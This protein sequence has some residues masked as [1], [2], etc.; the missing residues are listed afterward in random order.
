MN[1]CIHFVIRIEKKKHWLHDQ[2]AWSIPLLKI[3]GIKLTEVRNEGELIK[4]STYRVDYTK[5]TLQGQGVQHF[6]TLTVQ[7]CF[8]RRLSTWRNVILSNCM[9]LAGMLIL[10]LIPFAPPPIQKPLKASKQDSVTMHQQDVSKDSTKPVSLTRQKAN[11]IPF[12]QPSYVNKT[13]AV[14]DPEHREIIVTIGVIPDS[15]GKNGNPVYEDFGETQD[16]ARI[17]ERNQY[18]VYSSLFTPSFYTNGIFQQIRSSN[19]SNI[20]QASL[21]AR[22]D[23][24]CIGTV[25]RHTRTTTSQK[26]MFVAEIQL[27]IKF[28]SLQ[29]GKE[30]RHIDKTISSQ[31]AF[32]SEQALTQANETLKKF[33]NETL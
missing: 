6:D 22:A 19:F 27:Q 2:H 28:L 12:A 18:V 4:R 1:S 14:N 16:I 5:L 3:P 11:T 9:G 7:L 13:T 32:T 29:N 10:F 17:L 8:T 31:A 23:E 30:L 20:P 15:A 25:W 21:N 26:N 33:L 24:L